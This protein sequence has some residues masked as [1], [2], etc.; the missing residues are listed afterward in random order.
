MLHKGGLLKIAVT[1]V[2]SLASGQNIDAHFLFAT[3]QYI[4]LRLYLYQALLTAVAFCSF[5]SSFVVVFTIFV[6]FSYQFLF[7]VIFRFYLWLFSQILFVVIFTVFF[8]FHL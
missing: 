2:G 6:C 1:S 7:V 5:R 8:S 4:C 3:H